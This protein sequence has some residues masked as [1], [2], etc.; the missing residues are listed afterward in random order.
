MFGTA[1][2]QRPEQ[3]LQIPA[4][5]LGSGPQMPCLALSSR[6]G[7]VLRASIPLS[8]PSIWSALSLP[9]VSPPAPVGSDP[10][11]EAET[12]VSADEFWSSGLERRVLVAV[13]EPAEQ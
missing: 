8:A 12:L 5:F 3:R 10:A 4:A 2:S 13:W 6:A 9:L 7:S 1:G 11:L